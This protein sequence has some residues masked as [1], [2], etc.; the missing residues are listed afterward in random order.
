[1]GNQGQQGQ[2]KDQGN[3]PHTPTGTSGRQSGDI[4]P[5]G[6]DASTPRPNDQNVRGNRLHLDEDEESGL[7]NRTT[8]R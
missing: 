7:G 8:N 3:Q 1:M 5:G 4:H 6:N 2:R